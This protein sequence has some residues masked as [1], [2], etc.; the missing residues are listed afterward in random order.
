M[1][2]RCREPLD[3]AILKMNEKLGQNREPLATRGLRFKTLDPS[4]FRLLA[5]EPTLFL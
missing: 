2:C 3:A 1:V 4:L 5:G